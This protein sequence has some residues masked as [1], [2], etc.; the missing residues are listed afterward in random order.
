MADFAPMRSTTWCTLALGLLAACGGGDEA[1]PAAVPSGSSPAASDE[2]REEIL[3]PE[4]SPR[5]LPLHGVEELT[6]LIDLRFRALGTRMQIR[7]FAGIERLLAPEFRGHDLF[8]APV[9]EREDLALGSFREIH[10]VGRA[11]VVD[12][13]GFVAAMERHIGPWRR[14]EQS[15]LEVEKAEFRDG[16]PP[17]TGRVFLF[18]KLIGVTERGGRRSITAHAVGQVDAFPDGNGGTWKISKLKV[19]SAESLERP[20]A[21][22]VDVSRSA[23]VAHEGIRYGKPGNDDDA[24]NGAAAGDV[25]G[26]GRFDVFTPS[27]RRN[28][29]YRNAGDGGFAEEAEQRGLLGTGGGTGCVFFDFD[30]DGDQDLALA[31]VGW[32]ELDEEPGGKTLEFYENGGEGRFDEVADRV[33]LAVRREG[34][35]WAVLDH[36]ADGFL[37]LFLCGY[38]RIEGDLN[39]SWVE[40]TNGAKNSLFRNVDGDRFEDVAENVGIDDS[41]WTYA[42]AAADYDRDGDQDLYVVNSFGSNRMYRNDGGKFT[43]VAPELGM[44]E[45]GNGLSASWGDLNNDGRLDLFL[46]NPASN[47]GQRILNHIQSSVRA[48]MMASLHRMA[49]GNT[50]FLADGAG[51]F[52]GS[53]KE[54]GAANAHWAWSSTLCDLNLDGALDVFCPNGFVTGDLPHDT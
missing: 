34:Y 45:P 30:N 26:D 10:D 44:V 27:S 37:D 46:T 43:D 19:E 53:R 42:A 35:S 4:P 5:V 48:E 3:I 20:T 6:A 25:D 18:L 22:F 33:G 1:D 16:E 17:T 7:D 13:A 29:L 40:A 2:P 12:R 41:R 31:Q 28:F 52:E 24:W 15:I 36:D 47:A 54:S 49:S 51:G 39:D 23:G 38:G 14:I 50:L 21:L 9:K 8:G 11:A 32:F